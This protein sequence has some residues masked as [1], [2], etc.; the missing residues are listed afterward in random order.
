MRAVLFLRREEVHRHTAGTHT[1]HKQK[2]D[3]SA[4]A[5]PEAPCLVCISYHRST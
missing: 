4:A 2:Q 1:E 3:C 5:G